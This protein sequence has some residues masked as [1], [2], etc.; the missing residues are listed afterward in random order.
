MA[1]HIESAVRSGILEARGAAR[2]AG[3]LRLE[4]EARS[5][6]VS[7]QNANR[8][9]V[10]RVAQDTAR[11]RYYA[12]RYIKAWIGAANGDSVA[13]A[14]AT[15]SLKTGARLEMLGLTE[16]SEAF[17]DGRRRYVETV[18]ST[19]LMR[20]WDSAHDVNTCHRCAGADGTVV[21][22]RESFPLGEPGTVHP[23][24]LCTWHLI[25]VDELR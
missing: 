3:L 11:A 12:S 1:P 20:M 25:T 15:A 2:T 14:A 19:H 6:G 7:L 8:A 24:C 22:Y 5:L 16:G 23:R 18:L 13:E 10:S 9:I 21:G 17:N 4:A